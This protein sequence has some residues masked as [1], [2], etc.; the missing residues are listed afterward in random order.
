MWTKSNA[1]TFTRSSESVKIF[2]RRI[3]HVVSINE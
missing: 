1:A 3:Q 2:D